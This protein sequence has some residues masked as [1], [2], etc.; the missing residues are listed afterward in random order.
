MAGA[1]SLWSRI[2]AG[3]AGSFVTASAVVI[4]LP[5]FTR[6]HKVDAVTTASMVGF[7][8]WTGAVI[9]V[10]AAR[11]ATRAWLG[12]MATTLACVSVVWLAGPA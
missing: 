2:V 7:A 1:A 6:G 9:W 12:L 8:V 10:F 4:A 11:T 5:V 3:I